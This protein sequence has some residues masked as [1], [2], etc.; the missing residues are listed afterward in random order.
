MDAIRLDSLERELA[1]RDK[2]FADLNAVI[3]GRQPVETISPKDTSAKFNP[4][5]FSSLPEDQALRNQVEKEEKF[6]LSLGPNI[7][8]KYKPCQPSFFPPGKGRCHRQI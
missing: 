2:Y 7:S 6:N 5:K 8:G 4:V 3:S 1:L